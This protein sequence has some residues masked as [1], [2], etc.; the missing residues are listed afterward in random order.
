MRGEGL[1]V[2]A[3]AFLAFV[4][5]LEER[6]EVELL[7]ELLRADHE[8]RQRAGC[9]LG[10][11]RAQHAGAV[12]RDLG[13]TRPRHQRDD[14]RHHERTEIGAGDEVQEVER[15]QVDDV[16]VVDVAAL[17]TDDEAELLVGVL[18]HER[19]V[20]DDERLLVRAVRSG[21]HDRAARDVDLRRGDAEGARA[22][23]GDGVDARELAIRHLHRV[24]E[25][26]ALLSL[27]EDTDRAGDGQLDGLGGV[28]RRAGLPVQDVGVIVLALH[29]AVG[30][31][32]LP[33]RDEGVEVEAQISR[34]VGHGNLSAQGKRGPRASQRASG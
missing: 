19:G 32:C 28:E 2:P 7:V 27:L 30:A 22:L 33:S 4:V 16:R 31:L 12:A 8:L 29:R 10:V 6:V 14:R 21:V 24:A 26:V 15:G 18:I 23:L 20:D 34:G 17:V 3:D 13:A 25:Q 5:L 9:H 11:L 1:H